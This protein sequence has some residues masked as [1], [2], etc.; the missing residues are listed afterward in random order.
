[1][2]KFLLVLLIFMT[3]WFTMD[4]S[5]FGDF[6]KIEKSKIEKSLKFNSSRKS[7]EVDNVFGAVKVTGYNGD[8]LKLRISKTIKAKTKEALLKAKNEVKLDITTDNGKILLY[9]DG[10]FRDDDH[11]REG[12]HSKKMKYIVQY[13]MEIL[14]PRK[15]ELSIKTV[16]E[17][18]ID[19]QKIIGNCKVRHAN[20]KIFIKDLNGNFN[21]KTANGKIEAIKVNGSGDVYTANGKVYVQ[22]TKNPVSDCSFKT[23][24][25]N[26]DVRFISGLSG[27]FNL[28]TLHG[29]IFSDFPF[30]YLPV[31]QMKG[32]RKD[33]RFV[34]KSNRF[35]S[36]KVGKGGPTISMDTL[37]GSLI[38]GKGV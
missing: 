25:G 9:V 11:R 2:K 21:L 19:I 15:V 10:P 33:G 35:N 26:V 7:L 12:R 24:N 32:T 8:V 27:S 14:V 34:Y 17:G 3:A 4:G 30:E 13:D 22:F 20:G 38:I 23:I 16:T 1:M 28:K 36:I 6:D 5:D 31:K 37:N 29:K 18:D